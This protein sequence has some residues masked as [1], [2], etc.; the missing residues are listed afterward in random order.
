LSS[1]ET[2]QLRN[3]H[4]LDRPR[5]DYKSFSWSNE[6][7]AALAKCSRRSM[8]PLNVVDIG[9]ESRK[10]L[11]R[12]TYLRIL[13][14]NHLPGDTV[15]ECGESDLTLQSLRQALYSVAVDTTIVDHTTS[16]Y[17]PPYEPFAW[18]KQLP[19]ECEFD[20]I[21]RIKDELTR[22]QS[23]IRSR[24]NEHEELL[25]NL[26]Q[27]E[28]STLAVVN[29]FFGWL[30]LSPPLLPTHEEFERQNAP[31]I[32]EFQGFVTSMNALKPNCI[33]DSSVTIDCNPV[34]LVKAALEFQVLNILDRHLFYL[35][36][37]A[38]ETNRQREFERN[39]EK[40]DQ[41]VSKYR[42]ER[43]VES[44]SVPKHSRK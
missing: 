32:S 16:V 7:E 3:Y 37:R 21:K 39:N 22:L 31:K 41:L 36:Y 33:D 28:P 15:F 34:S 35:E 12:C 14:C 8:Q 40:A 1:L 5:I 44:R 43:V 20:F 19:G 6:Y 10:Q 29:N 4:C 2:Y 11:S 25:R 9:L 18:T 42:K 30:F 13:P 24:E 26:R 23:I 27:H 17:W 38:G